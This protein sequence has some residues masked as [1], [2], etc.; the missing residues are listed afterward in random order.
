MIYSNIVTLP[1]EPRRL[2]PVL[3]TSRIIFPPGFH[4]PHSRCYDH[5]VDTRD[6]NDPNQCRFWRTPGFEKNGKHVAYFFP[7]YLRVAHG[8]CNPKVGCI[9][10]RAFVVEWREKGTEPPLRRRDIYF[11]SPLTCPYFIPETFVR[12][13]ILSSSKFGTAFISKHFDYQGAI[14]NQEV[15][16]VNQYSYGPNCFERGIPGLPRPRFTQSRRRSRHSSKESKD[17]KQLQKKLRT[18]ESLFHEQRQQEA[19]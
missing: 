6:F 4:P 14:P 18:Q 8:E 17:T 15:I 13:L 5:C 16:V 2:E 9:Y 3:T 10:R 7:Y 19:S 12:K 11:E 1:P